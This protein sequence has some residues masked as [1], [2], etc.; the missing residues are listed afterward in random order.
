MGTNGKDKK[1]KKPEL[2]RLPIPEG[3]GRGT[4]YFEL[5]QRNSNQ[6][7]RFELQV[8]TTLQGLQDRF[9]ESTLVDLI[10]DAIIAKAR[11]I[12]NNALQKNSYE[13]AYA[14]VLAWQPD[15]AQKERDEKRAA[16][17]KAELDKLSPE[18]RELVLAS[19]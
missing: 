12:A 8:P 18:V 13:V 6:A 10:H 9:T 11:G 7:L 3:L 17:L 5:E 4:V 2:V 15:T 1:D 14:A 16:K 19:K